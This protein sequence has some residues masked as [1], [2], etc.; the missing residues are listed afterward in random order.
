MNKYTIT[1]IILSLGIVAAAAIAGS[2]FKNRNFSDNIILVTGLGTKTFTSD[3]ITWSGRFTQTDYELKVAYE[4]LESN[5]NTIRE[6]LI[7]K[8]IPEDQ[9]IFSAVNTYKRTNYSTDEYGRSREVF[10][11]YELSQSVSIESK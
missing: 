6:Y 8:G 7:S 2:A 4:G 3:L 11:G 9:I 5:R 10:A 1:A